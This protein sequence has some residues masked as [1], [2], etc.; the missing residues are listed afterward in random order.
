MTT[1][2]ANSIV[3]FAEPEGL[4]YQSTFQRLRREVPFGRAMIS[5]TLPRGGLQVIQAPAA[6][7]AW[8]RTYSREHHLLDAVAWEGLLRR[9]PVRLSK[10]CAGM[11]APSR[12][13]VSQFEATA[14]APAQLGHY[15][16]A[17]LAAPLLD[18]YPGA[19]QL[20]RRRGEPDFDDEELG[21]LGEA[22]QALD[23]AASEVRR[24]RCNGDYSD[25]PSHELAC[26][27]IAAAADGRLLFP[28]ESSDAFDADVLQNLLEALAV[29]I[30]RRGAELQRRKAPAEKSSR[31]RR[32]DRLL[33]ATTSAALRV[34]DRRGEQWVFR[35]VLYE[36]FPA[37]SGDAREPVAVA[38]LPPECDSWAQLR[39]ID[40]Q[41][42]ND[43]ARL[44]PALQYMHQHFTAGINLPE[45]ARSVNLSPFHFHRRFTELLGTTPKHFLFDCQIANAKRE[46]AKGQKPL[47]EIA[48]SAGFAHQSHF[49]SRFRQATGLTPTKW[50]RLAAQTTPARKA[51]GPRDFTH[52]ESHSDARGIVRP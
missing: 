26:R 35:L 14:L 29:Q 51:S 49:T 44:I 16:A 42:D 8:T 13:T 34:P 1:A 36:F 9:Q 39:P 31:A 21:R 48:A 45:V 38:S 43:L 3:V 4:N 11:A 46:L 17:P 37:L 28:A 18:G 7:P 5:T 22:A 33:P 41:A 15:A 12:A 30:A 52:S 32:P 25:S 2:L 10:L 19:L 40:I 47:S 24:M 27:Q 50:K 20:F 23:E 6:D